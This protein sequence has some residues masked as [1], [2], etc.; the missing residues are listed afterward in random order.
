MSAHPSAHVQVLTIVE[1]TIDRTKGAI[2]GAL[3]LIWEFYTCLNLQPDHSVTYDEYIY[4]PPSRIG[5]I[6]LLMFPARM[7]PTPNGQTKELS[8]WVER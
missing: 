2:K 6:R 8:D 4:A 7:L 3:L 5:K 1:Q